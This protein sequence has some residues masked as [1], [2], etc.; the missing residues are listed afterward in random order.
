MIIMILRHVFFTGNIQQHELPSY[1]APAVLLV[2]SSSKEGLPKLVLESLA[3]GTPVVATN[4]ASNAKVIT[5]SIA[6]ELITKR[7]VESIAQSIMS[8]LSRKIATATVRAFAKLFG[9]QHVSEKQYLLLDY[10]I[11]ESKKGSM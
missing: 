3:S 2:L 1:Y 5:Q 11:T 8:V 4:V 7:Y 10:L 6:G 9:W